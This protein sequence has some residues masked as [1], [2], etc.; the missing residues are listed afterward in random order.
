[1]RR[2]ALGHGGDND[3]R[4]PLHAC[5]AH[6]AEK[7]ALLM[8]EMGADIDATLQGDWLGRS[9]DL[10]D[11]GTLVLPIRHQAAS[12]LSYT[13][14]VMSAGKHKRPTLLDAH[15]GKSVCWSAD[16]VNANKLIQKNGYVWHEVGGRGLAPLFSDQVPRMAM[17]GAPRSP[18]AEVI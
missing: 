16:D 3:G 11:D 1:M 12:K 17:D 2:P 14:F 10:N 4:T 9:V 15:L 7:A 5:A 13:L 18:D 8:I 6:G